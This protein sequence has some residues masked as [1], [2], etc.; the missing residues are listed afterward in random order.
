MECRND[1]EQKNNKKNREYSEHIICKIK[2]WMEKRNIT[3][4]ELGEK[5]G[6]NQSSVSKILKNDNMMKIDDLYKISQ[7]LNVKV[8]ELL[9]PETYTSSVKMEESE[10][11]VSSPDKMAYNGLMGD[12][13]FYCYRTISREKGFLKGVLRLEEGEQENRKYCRVLLY[14]KTGK[15]N[16]DG[17]PIEKVYEGKMMISVALNSCF[18]EMYSKKY[19]DCVYLNF[20]HMNLFDEKFE[21]GVVGCL[22]TSAGENKRP[23][24]LK[25]IIAR[26]ELSDQQLDE[27]SGIIK[28][29]NRVIRIEEQDFE[30]IGKEI[31]EDILKCFQEKKYYE[32][33]EAQIRGINKDAL[34]TKSKEYITKLRK[35][36]TSDKYIKVSSKTDEI[37]FDYLKKLV[38]ENDKEMH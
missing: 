14:L 9:E 3:Q 13:N 17:K 19:A 35:V 32:T 12:Y 26:K 27:L 11:L 10:L 16:K 15:Y 34:R 30:R 22:T 28:M 18:V 37:L 33:D 1:E 7:A 2:Y 36:S 5:L 31:P 8:T 38:N 21:C 4:K 20:H 6:K 29:N 23:V 24:F 25:A